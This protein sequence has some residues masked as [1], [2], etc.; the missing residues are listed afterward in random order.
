MKTLQDLIKD[1][2]G[3]T[4]EQNKINNYL[5]RKFLDLQDADLRGADLK[6]IEITKKQLDQLIVIEDNE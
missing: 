2:T 5:S 1:L 6:N 3:V 4:V